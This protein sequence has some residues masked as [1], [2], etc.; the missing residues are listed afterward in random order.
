MLSASPAD[1]PYVR[2]VLTG[3]ND[4]YGGDF[5]SRLLTTLQFNH[6]EL[7]G[8]G[9]AHEF[10]LVEWA[11]VPGARLL[12]DLVEEQ[13]PPSVAASLRTIVVDPSYH[14]AMTLNPDRKSTRLNSS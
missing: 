1:R 7:S 8:R 4:G 10:I 5:V 14:D 2:L 9:I 11:P 12:A 6:R 3:H 13:C